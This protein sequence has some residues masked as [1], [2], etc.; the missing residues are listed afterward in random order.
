MEIEILNAHSLDAR[1]LLGEALE[2]LHPLMVGNEE[3]EIPGAVGEYV[4]AHK[5]LDLKMFRTTSAEIGSSNRVD[6]GVAEIPR[7]YGGRAVPIRARGR[8]YHDARDAPSFGRN[9]SASS[10]T[11]RLQLSVRQRCG[12]ISPIKWSPRAGASG[13]TSR[14]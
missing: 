6:P 8:E 4:E 11:S 3:E 5:L 13:A 14:C 12:S 9:P 10:A 2:D 7:G 1:H